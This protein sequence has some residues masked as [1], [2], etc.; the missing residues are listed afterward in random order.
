MNDLAQACLKV[1][2]SALFAGGV[3]FL[4]LIL[5]PTFGGIGGW[6][7]SLV[8]NDTFASLQEFLG[9]D[10]NGFQIGAALA[11]VGAFLKSTVSNSK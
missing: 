9:T 6:V 5:A 8:F 3:L 11:F 2:G 10:A 7:F 4:L 1:V